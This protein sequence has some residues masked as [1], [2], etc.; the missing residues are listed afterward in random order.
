[1][2]NEQAEIGAVHIQTTRPVIG[3][4]CSNWASR[5]RCACDWQALRA[6]E[7]IKKPPAGNKSASGLEA[8][9]GGHLVDHSR[10]IDAL[11]KAL[12]SKPWTPREQLDPI[13]AAWS[14]DKT[15]KSMDAMEV[16][17]VVKEFGLHPMIRSDGAGSYARPLVK[18]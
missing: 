4:V 1:L 16:E 9:F 8:R 13:D 7:A 12:W 17:A 6:K 2:P 15:E 18:A 14:S 10:A 5:K 3:K 11:A